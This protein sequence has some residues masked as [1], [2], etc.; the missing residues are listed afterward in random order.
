MGSGMA[1]T[2]D[3]QRHHQPHST[4]LHPAVAAMATAMVRRSSSAEA[5]SDSEDGGS[6]GSYHGALHQHNR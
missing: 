4:R 6:H 3:A 2:L 1:T 5:T